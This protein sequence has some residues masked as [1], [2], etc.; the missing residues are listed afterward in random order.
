MLRSTNKRPIIH[1]GNKATEALKK[2]LHFPWRF[3][4]KLSLLLKD[5]GQARLLKID[6][7]AMLLQS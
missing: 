1:Y 7:G 6:Q 2:N 5:E 3:M 4:D